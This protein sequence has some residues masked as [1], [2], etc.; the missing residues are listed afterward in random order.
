MSRLIDIPSEKGSYALLFSNRRAHRISVGSLGTFLFP[1]GYYVYFGS[2]HGYGGLLARTRRC[3]VQPAVRNWHIDDLLPRVRV[4]GI[5]YTVEQDIWFY[6][7]TPRIECDWSQ[8]AYL[9]LDVQGVVAPGFG[10]SDCS[11]GCP[12]H[13]FW[14]AS[15]QK[16][17]ALLCKLRALSGYEIIAWL[18]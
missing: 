12:A 3:L 14:M 13:L 16:R 1:Q 10:S 8:M 6:F 11:R 4:Q 18:C 9:M 2:A 7:K 17:D 15:A 5:W